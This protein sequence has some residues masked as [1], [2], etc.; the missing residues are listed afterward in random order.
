[1]DLSMNQSIISG[2]PTISKRKY[3]FKYCP[4]SKIHFLTSKILLFSFASL[5][6]LSS[7][8][9]FSD[10]YYE[11]YLISNFYV[12]SNKLIYN[13]YP[14]IDI[15]YPTIIQTN[16]DP[17]KTDLSN[18]FYVPG[19]LFKS[20]Y[21]ENKTEYTVKNKTLKTE[22]V[23][24]ITREKNCPNITQN[25]IKNCNYTWRNSSQTF[26]QKGENKTWD[27]IKI[28][29]V[30]TKEAEEFKLNIIAL[31]Y[32]VSIMDDTGSIQDCDIYEKTVS[33]NYSNNIIT[34]DGVQKT[35]ECD[36][37]L[38][39]YYDLNYHSRVVKEEKCEDMNFPLSS[40][41]KLKHIK[42]EITYSYEYFILTP[43]FILQEISLLSTVD[44]VTTKKFLIN[45]IFLSFLEAIAA[46]ILLTLQKADNNY[47][48]DTSK[49]SLFESLS[50]ISNI[51]I[52]LFW[53]GMLFA[54]K[55]QFF[56]FIGAHKYLHYCSLGTNFICL[57][58]NGYYWYISQNDYWDYF[59]NYY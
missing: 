8:L 20:L 3:K 54:T 41:V 27:D 56:I 57:G 43:E 53:F 18:Y 19:K 22:C 6:Y 48:T 49:I 44:G 45:L 7:I 28:Q 25:T 31:W 51:L 17:Y 15:E 23:Y 26:Y 4:K 36:L 47:N 42:T 24:D 9:T 40:S 14:N 10:A 30:M 16:T 1:M 33:H 38:E 5:L 29:Q 46:S 35:D 11:Y 55:A 39:S 58:L 13:L 2:E 52:L 37:N 32:D 50:L 12:Y 59:E 21:N 34:A